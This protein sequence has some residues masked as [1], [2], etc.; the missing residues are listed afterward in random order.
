MQNIRVL[1]VFL[2]ALGCRSPVAPAG[3]EVKAELEGSAP[4]FGRSQLDE[5]V[6]EQG[7]VPFPLK[8]L[9]STLVATYKYDV[10]NVFI[11]YSR[12]L[13]KEHVSLAKPRVILIATGF[14]REG[15]LEQ[16]VRFPD[17][18]M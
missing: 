2:V 13:Q 4:P 6:A 8:K 5:L 11:P 18:P 1:A 15:R 17:V 12:S 14:G 16:E 10:Q 7:G 3:S 9:R